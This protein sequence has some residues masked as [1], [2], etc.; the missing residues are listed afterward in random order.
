MRD[1]LSLLMQKITFGRYACQLTEWGIK[2]TSRQESA[3]LRQFLQRTLARA[4]QF[5]GIFHPICVHQIFQVATEIAVYHV[6]QISLVRFNHLAQ[7]FQRELW[8]EEYLAHFQIV[9][10]IFIYLTIDS[11][12]FFYSLICE[13]LLP[14]KMSCFEKQIF[15]PF[16]SKG[17]LVAV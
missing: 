11:S 12:Y 8:V 5:L 6:G 1:V 4:K 14:I 17:A 13:F 10:Y 7:F 15:L 2:G 9:Q 16:G 3:T